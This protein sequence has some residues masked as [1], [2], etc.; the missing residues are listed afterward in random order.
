MFHLRVVFLC[1]EILKWRSVYRLHL[2]WNCEI[3]S[4]TMFTACTLDNLCI[5]SG[6]ETSSTRIVVQNEGLD[7]TAEII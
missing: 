6:S 7:E 5:G 1:A 4:G 2:C 3:S